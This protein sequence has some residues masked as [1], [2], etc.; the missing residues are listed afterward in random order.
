MGVPVLG[1]SALALMAL[2][3][4]CQFAYAQPIAPDEVLA[5]VGNQPTGIQPEL[6]NFG[7]VTRNL[8]RSAQPNSEHLRVL[9]ERYGLRTVISLKSTGHDEYLINDL[10]ARVMRFSLNPQPIGIDTVRRDKPNIVRALRALRHAVVQKPTLLHCTNGS[11]R[12]GL[13]TALYRMIYENLPAEAA[14]R[15][16]RQYDFHGYLR[17]I[18]AFIREVD[19][20]ALG[21]E[22]GVP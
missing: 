19:V 18:P 14:I 15:E 20:A 17:G 1:L 16:M 13:V 11:D 10:P 21:R 2:L 6:A 8:Y 12:T 22:V 5:R 9:H 3:N 7:R 4:L